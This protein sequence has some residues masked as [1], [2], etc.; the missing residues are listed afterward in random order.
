[1]KNAF[2]LIFIFK[3]ND[4]MNRLFG[5]LV[6]VVNI[7]RLYDSYKLTICQL[8]KILLFK[9]KENGSIYLQNAIPLQLKDCTMM[10]V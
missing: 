7:K 4:K 1:M 10:Y 6:Q 5:I 3:I 8:F 2:F 9:L